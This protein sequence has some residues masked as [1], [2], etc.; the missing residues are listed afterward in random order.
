LLAYGV[1]AAASTVAT[2]GSVARTNFAP[3][4]GSSPFADTVTLEAPLAAGQTF[5]VNNPSGRTTIH[6]GSSPNIHVVATRHNSLGGH[7]P[8]VRLTPADSGVTLEASNITRGFPFGGSSSVDYAIEVPA[9][10]GV[11]AQSASGQVEID[12][13]GGAVQAET[14]SGSL[15]LSNLGGAVQARS[16]S[17]SIALSNVGGDVNVSTSSGQIRGT[18]L[19]HVR[20]ASTSSGSITLEGVFNDQASIKAS[21]GTVS[22]KLLPG[23]AVQLN[24]HTGGG[25][26]VAPSGLPSG[27]S[28]SRTSL[29]GTVGSP[30]EG[31]TLSIETSSGSVLLSQ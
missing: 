1:L 10:V 13:V 20:Q 3:G 2:G 19:Q 7:A 18:Q 26:I 25:S 4:F 16:S 12:G 23:S 5:S 11:K 6:T 31:A 24:V 8:D 28:S 27:V 17:G 15:N 30:A 29:S 9:S 14:T 21:S 22:V